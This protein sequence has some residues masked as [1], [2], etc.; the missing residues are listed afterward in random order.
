MRAAELLAIEYAS[1]GM[2]SNQFIDACDEMRPK[3]LR[4]V[5]VDMLGST[6][7]P[8]VADWIPPEQ[9]QRSKLGDSHVDTDGTQW[10]TPDGES[11]PVVVLRT[12]A[13]KEKFLRQIKVK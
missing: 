5:S 10:I 12:V 3:A 4:F 8:R 1:R 2:N 13:D 9:R 7:G 6:I 11:Q